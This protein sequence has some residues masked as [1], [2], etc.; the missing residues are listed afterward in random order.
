MRQGNWSPASLSPRGSQKSLGSEVAQPRQAAGCGVSGAPR[1]HRLLGDQVGIDPV[2]M[3]QFGSYKLIS[4]Q[5]LALGSLFHTLP[6]LQVCIPILAVSVSLSNH[7]GSGGKAF[8]L[9]V[10]DQGSEKECRN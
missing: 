10:G 1:S 5:P 7:P 9:L 6:F 3:D 8:L 2:A 4:S